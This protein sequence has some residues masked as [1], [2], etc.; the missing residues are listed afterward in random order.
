ME[1]T[2]HVSALYL[3][4]EWI[5]SLEV[6]LVLFLSFTCEKATVIWARTA[7][8]VISSSP[9]WGRAVPLRMFFPVL[10]FNYQSPA[11]GK[12]MIIKSNTKK[13]ST[14]TFNN[15]VLCQIWSCFSGPMPGLS[16]IHRMISSLRHSNKRKNTAGKITALTTASTN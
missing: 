5:Q 1:K 6:F 12:E 8:E 14:S 13:A 3:G 10:R 11:N 16:C 4:R 7:Y 9:S 2:F 15:S